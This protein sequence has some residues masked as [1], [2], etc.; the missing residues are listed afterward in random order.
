MV[1]VRV[2][3][4]GPRY[5]RSDLGKIIDL[6]NGILGYHEYEYLLAHVVYT[7]LMHNAIYDTLCNSPRAVVSALDVQPVPR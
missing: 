6:E 4:C 5:G 3:A 2:A 1:G 7:M